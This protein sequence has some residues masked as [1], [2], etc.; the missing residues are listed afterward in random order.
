MGPAPLPR[1]G[2]GVGGWGGEMI[3]KKGNT[4][5]QIAKG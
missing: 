5:E 1:T 4:F 2:E 3:L